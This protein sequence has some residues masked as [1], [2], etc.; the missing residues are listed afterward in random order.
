MQTKMIWDSNIVKF[1]EAVNEFLS[2]PN[3]QAI[4]VD[5]ATYS[6]DDST[7]FSA[8]ILYIIK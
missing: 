7:K 2:N 8:M 3:V 4:S 5:Y 1:E 6:E